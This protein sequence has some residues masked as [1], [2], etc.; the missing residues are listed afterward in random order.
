LGGKGVD[1]DGEQHTKTRKAL[2]FFATELS[3]GRS[4][5]GKE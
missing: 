3:A 2:E 5:D 4:N 1:L